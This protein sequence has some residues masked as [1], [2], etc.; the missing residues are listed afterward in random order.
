MKTKE[1]IL[2]LYSKMLLNSEKI[3]DM[4]LN[5][6]DDMSFEEIK[7]LICEDNCQYQMNTLIEWVLDIDKP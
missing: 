3:H 7:K 6:P 4:V 5:P 2:E 1:E